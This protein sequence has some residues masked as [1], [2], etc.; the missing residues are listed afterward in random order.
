VLPR[1]RWEFEQWLNP[2][3]KPVGLA[4]YFEP[5]YKGDEQELEYKVLLSKNIGDQ[6]LLAANVA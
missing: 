2:N 6:W 5:T 1:G 4:L 3:P